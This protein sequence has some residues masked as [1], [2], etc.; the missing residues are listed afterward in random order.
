[1][2]ASLPARVSTCGFVSAKGSAGAALAVCACWV[3]PRIGCRGSFSDLLCLL[4]VH[5]RV[6]W[7]SGGAHVQWWDAKLSY[8]YRSRQSAQGPPDDDSDHPASPAIFFNSVPWHYV[9]LI[10]VKLTV[11][12]SVPW[13]VMCY[14]FDPEHHSIECQVFESPRRAVLRRSLPSTALGRQVATKPTRKTA[15][16]LP[17]QSID[18]V[19]CVLRAREITPSSCHI[20]QRYIYYGVASLGSIFSAQP[21]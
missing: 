21:R 20:V 18:L 13:Q 19:H 2:C 8:S 4:G 16:M 9:F 1:M 5:V 17:R 6:I 12:I 10:L 15:S 14:E 3:H 7:K 11:P